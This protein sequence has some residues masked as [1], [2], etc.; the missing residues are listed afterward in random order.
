MLV[1]SFNLLFNN[2]YLDVIK[3]VKNSS[4]IFSNIKFD[5]ERMIVYFYISDK[6]YWFEIGIRREDIIF[7]ILFPS[8]F[9]DK[10]RDYLCERLTSN[11][12]FEKYNNKVTAYCKTVKIENLMGQGSISHSSD[13]LEGSDSISYFIYNTFMQLIEKTSI[14]QITNPL[15][16]MESCFG[17]GACYNICPSAAI[18]MVENAESFLEPIINED[19]CIH[20]DACKKVCPALHPSFPHSTTPKIHAFVGDPDTVYAS[21]SGGAFT[22][23]A[24]KYLASDGYVVGAAFAE[25][26]SVRHIIISNSDDLDKLRRS[27]YVQSDQGLCYRETK[28][29]LDASKQVLYSGTPCQIAGLKGFLGKEYDNLVT[30]D[31]LCHGVPPQKHLHEYLETVYGIKNIATVEMRGREWRTHFRVAMRNGQIFNRILY[32]PLSVTALLC[33]KKLQVKA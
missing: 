10:E 2:I 33:S 4:D 27:K 17:C 12:K 21:S 1:R 29:L 28:K 20:C 6:Q 23:L 24:E 15:E 14:C 3:M 11:Y 16:N 8:G 25:D 7:K 18:S 22:L 26:F 9:D 30:I 31:L 13:G 19:T 32:K 5:R